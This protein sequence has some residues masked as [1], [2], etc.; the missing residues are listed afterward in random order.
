VNFAANP[1][2]K[3]FLTRLEGHFAPIRCVLRAY[4]ARME[5]MSRRKYAPK[6]PKMKSSRRLSRRHINR[7]R[8]MLKSTRS[9]KKVNVPS[10]A[11]EGENGP[12]AVFAS[13]LSRAQH[14]GPAR[15]RSETLNSLGQIKEPRRG[16]T[17]EI[18]LKRFNFRIP[19]GFDAESFL[20]LR[21]SPRT[22][23]R[24]SDDAVVARES[25]EN[26]SAG[27]LPRDAPLPS[28]GGRGRDEGTFVYVNTVRASERVNELRARAHTCPCTDTECIINRGTGVAIKLRHA[29]LLYYT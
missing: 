11:A 16:V 21:R 7:C 24:S 19:L 12:F 5:R 1:L 10:F 26:R 18:P 25:A 29:L 3:R 14:R 4:L 23:S 17:F 2:V 15:A 9:S 8:V 27:P 28:T 13:A 6:L 22:L 20:G